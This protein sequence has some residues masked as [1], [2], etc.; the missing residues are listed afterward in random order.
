LD[1]HVGLVRGPIACELIAVPQDNLLSPGR[2][3]LVL[4]EVCPREGFEPGQFGGR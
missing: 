3:P 4:V 1:G 2:G